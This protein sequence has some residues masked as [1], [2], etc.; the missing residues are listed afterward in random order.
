MENLMESEVE[1]AT[2]EE[3]LNAIRWY[4]KFTSRNTEEDVQINY[5]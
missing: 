3:T 4:I 5:I 2:S 1:P